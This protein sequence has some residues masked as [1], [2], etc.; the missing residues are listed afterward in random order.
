MD[1]SRWKE[2]LI[3]TGGSTPQVV[4]ETV[5][6]LARREHD[7]IVPGKII[8]II[9]SGVAARFETELPQQLERLSVAWK[10]PNRW[11]QVQLEIPRYA[12]GAQLNDVRSHVDAVR[13]GD[14]VAKIVRQE[15]ANPKS[16]V[17]LSL[18]GGRKTMSYHGGAAM[19]LFGRLQDE[20]SHV[21]IE[22]DRFEGCVDFWFPTQ[23]SQ[24]VQHRD[25]SLLDAKDAGI[26]LSMNPFLR[27][28][29]HLPTW[30]RK[31]DLDY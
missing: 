13:F 19:T 4:T 20:L 25:G 1:A 7:P 22:P 6:A 30:L 21:L 9:T 3:V 8:C 28:G 11:G 29:E 14:L 12:S 10:I 18:A 26:E 15:T 17:H 23:E 24:I 31:Q 5:H 2:V 27:M 16:R